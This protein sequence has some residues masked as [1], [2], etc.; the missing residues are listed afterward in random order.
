LNVKPGSWKYYNKV[1]HTLPMYLGQKMESSGQKDFYTG[2][3]AEDC[4]CSERYGAEFYF[5][6][7][8]V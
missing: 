5:G 2:K 8:E 4:S 7:N 1:I 6:K 3:Q